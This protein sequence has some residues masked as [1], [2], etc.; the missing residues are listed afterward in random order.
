MRKNSKNLAKLFSLV[1]ESITTE[2]R[3]RV[4]ARALSVTFYQYRSP[5]SAPVRASIL[6]ICPQHRPMVCGNG[7]SNTEQTSHP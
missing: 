3:T 6:L 1:S 7:Y 4:R 5:H 2:S